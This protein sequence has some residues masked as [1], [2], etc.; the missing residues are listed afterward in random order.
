MIRPTLF[1]LGALPLFASNPPKTP[2]KTPPV[3]AKAP[4]LSLIHI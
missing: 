4:D 2:A 1:L 3:V